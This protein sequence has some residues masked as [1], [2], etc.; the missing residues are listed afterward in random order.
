MKVAGTFWT[1]VFREGTP[2]RTG[3]SVKRYRGHLET[4]VTAAFEL[5]NMQIGQTAADGLKDAEV[6]VVF[7]RAIL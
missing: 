2:T 7:K 3:A 4:A 6:R 1:L 5:M